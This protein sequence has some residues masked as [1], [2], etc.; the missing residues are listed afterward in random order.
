MRVPDTDGGRFPLT[1]RGDVKTYALFA[2][3]FACLTGQSAAL[4]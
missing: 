1:G 2:E 4:A 3:L